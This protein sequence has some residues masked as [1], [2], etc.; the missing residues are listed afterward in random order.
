VDRSSIIAIA[1]RSPIVLGAS[2]ITVGFVELNWNTTSSM[3]PCSTSL[4]PKTRGP[5]SPKTRGPW[6]IEA[7]RCRRWARRWR[8]GAPRLVACRA[9]GRA[10]LRLG[11]VASPRLRRVAEEAELQNLACL[12]RPVLRAIDDQVERLVD[13]AAK[14]RQARNGSA[15]WDCVIEDTQAAL[16][17]TRRACTG[18]KLCSLVFV[19][20][21][22]VRSGRPTM[23]LDYP[24]SSRS[25]PSS[26][27][28]TSQ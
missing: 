8:A 9:P 19:G 27:Q 28:S 25:N 12:N 24:P 17:T 14:Q 21:R 16:G 5:L 3:G 10:T 1:S 18:R 15:Y 22:P 4:S 13:Q 6:W 23:S 7:A 26:K 2:P 11:A 20:V